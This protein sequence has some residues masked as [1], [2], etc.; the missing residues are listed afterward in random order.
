[1]KP[2]ARA[3]LL[4]T[5]ATL[6]AATSHADDA[7][8]PSGD[9]ASSS[10][11]GGAAPIAPR[12][13]IGSNATRWKIPVNTAVPIFVEESSGAKLTPTVT[14][15]PSAEYTLTADT[16]S[17]R[18]EYYRLLKIPSAKAGDIYD[19]TLGGTCNSGTVVTPVSLRVEFTAESPLPVTLGT[20]A[21]TTQ[22]TTILTL[23]ASYL[24]FQQVSQ[25]DV[26]A[27]GS[28][29]GDYP[30]GIALTEADVFGVRA[31]VGGVCTVNTSNSPLLRAKLISMSPAL[32]C[33]NGRA[34]G[35]VEVNLSAQARI[36]GAATQPSAV[37]GTIHVDCAKA[38]DSE[39]AT[40][41]TNATNPNT[42][43]AVGTGCSVGSLGN[44]STTLG[45]LCALSF[46]LLVSRRR[47]S[48]R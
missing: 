13:D 29:I 1:M 3:S 17:P 36:P 14:V 6:T 40:S 4:I 38:T 41:G 24:P 42:V 10:A 9:V 37:S 22:G 26:S 47:R 19:V 32:F 44:A 45:G 2:S 5:F 12:C 15:S 11:S 27:A 39:L 30:A 43:N 31:C 28:V 23:D 21:E 7:K 8:R 20:M 18:P 34:S 25:I 48:A 35:V 33:K 16:G 46:A